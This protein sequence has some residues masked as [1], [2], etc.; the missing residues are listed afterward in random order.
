MDV[1]END[2]PAVHVRQPT[3]GIVAGA[4]GDDVVA[5]GADDANIHDFLHRDA[6]DP[7]AA[8]HR[9]EHDRALAGHAFTRGLQSGAEVDDRHDC[10]AEI[11]QSVDIARRARQP[12][13]GPERDNLANVVD[14]AAVHR[15]AD[16]K[17]QRPALTG[18]RRDG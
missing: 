2:R 1:E 5:R 7:R 17:E 4:V 11:D 6:D 9:H 18:A 16:A 3:H 8:R 14:V 12:R 10:S 15:A 13:G